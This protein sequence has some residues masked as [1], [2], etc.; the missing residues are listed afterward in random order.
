MF[1]ETD[2]LDDWETIDNYRIESD[3]TDGLD[4]QKTLD[5]Y[6]VDYRE[7]KAN[8]NVLYGLDEFGEV[9]NSMALPLENAAHTYTANQIY[10]H[11]RHIVKYKSQ[12]TDDTGGFR[13]LTEKA[14]LQRQ[15]IGMASHKQTELLFSLNSVLL[16]SSRKESKEVMRLVRTLLN[17]YVN[18]TVDTSNTPK[19][20]RDARRMVI[21]GKFSTMANFPAPKVFEINDHAC[22]SIKETI[23]IL[24]GHGEEFDLV[25]DAELETRSRCGLNGSSSAG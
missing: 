4:D 19:T 22:V 24:A 16:N 13:H 1:E 12:G 25:Y 20:Y 18:E 7:D 23:L 21:D 17:N 9:F 5:D 10:M 8:P 11:C 2:E 3:S 6:K 14:T 15:T